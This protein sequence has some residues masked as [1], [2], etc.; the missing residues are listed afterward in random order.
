[1]AQGIECHPNPESRLGQ[2][3]SVVRIRKKKRDYQSRASELEQAWPQI[4]LPTALGEA[5]RFQT[6]L[7]AAVPAPP[8]PPV[9]ADP[10]Q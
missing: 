6:E 1:M 10:V 4:A 7:L 2:Q 3:P 5:Y 8:A 9:T